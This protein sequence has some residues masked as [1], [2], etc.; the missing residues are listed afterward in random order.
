M[1][2]GRTLPASF[3]RRHSRFKCRYRGKLAVG[4][5]GSQRAEQA[6]LNQQPGV[7]RLA[8]VHLGLGNQLQQTQPQSRRR[9]GSE[10]VDQGNL[11]RTDRR[12]FRIAEGDQLRRAS[13]PSDVA[14]QLARIGAGVEGRC[15]G[16]ERSRCVSPGQRRDQR[17]QRGWIGQSQR[18]PRDSDRHR[19]LART[20]RLLEQY[21]RVSQAA[22]RRRR[23]EGDRVGV[24]VVVL[25][26]GDIGEQLLDRRHGH[27]PEVEAL[28]PRAHGLRNFVRLRGGKH[29]QHVRRRFLERLEKCVPRVRGEHVRLVDDVDLAAQ[30]RRQVA[31]LVAQV[32]HLVDATVAR[33]IDL[34][35]VDGGAAQDLEARWAYVV[36]LTVDRRVAVHGPCQDPS[37]RG[38][39]GP[40]D[41][42]EQVSV[43]QLT[44]SHLVDQRA[45][46]HLLPN[47]VG[48]A[49]RPV[50]AIEGE[51]HWFSTMDARRQC[52]EAGGIVPITA[53][54]R[55]K[56]R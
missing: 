34:E 56:T 24:D 29:E 10:V 41:T 6:H 37:S 40:T 17:V 51:A 54:R 22:L 39:A 12:T 50:S 42:G 53:V 47:Q 36:G 35:D 43:G 30:H 8:K 1:A 33:R 48:E 9:D 55:G 28:Y 15:S 27:T 19:P 52:F 11:I 2:L 16:A 49:L 21:Q 18:P 32:A 45:R 46:H 7:D 13:E 26:P 4:S 44:G 31:H 20:E 5:R 25:L 38:L 14:K 3:Q 23:K